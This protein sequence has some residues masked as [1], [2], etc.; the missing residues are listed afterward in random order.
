MNQTTVV[1]FRPHVAASNDK[2]LIDELTA[3]LVQEG[4]IE[5][6]VGFTDAVWER[7]SQQRTW[8]GRE[9]AIPHARLANV[10]KLALVIGSHSTGIE[11]GSP[12][13][14]AR[15]FFLAAVPQNGAVGYLY[16]TQRITRTLRD[17]KRRKALLA[18]ANPE[19]LSRAWNA[20]T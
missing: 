9:A 11:W 5:D 8:L 15:L 16:L 18:A 13:H 1:L 3:A 6:A 12:E 2:S 10:R 7:E 20:S 14:K 17:D 19:G 4:A